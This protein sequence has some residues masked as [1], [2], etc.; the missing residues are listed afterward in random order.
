MYRHQVIIVL[1]FALVNAMLGCSDYGNSNVNNP[2]DTDESNSYESILPDHTAPI[3]SIPWGEHQSI[4]VYGTYA[5]HDST[6]IDY[7]YPSGESVLTDRR[8]LNIHPG[9]T[10]LTL[11]DNDGNQICGASLI[12]LN[13]TLL[14]CSI[15]AEDNTIY[16]EN[17]INSDGIHLTL[18]AGGETNNISFPD[19]L[20]IQYAFEIYET[21]QMD[22]N[23]LQINSNKQ[24]VLANIHDW[25]LP[26]NSLPEIDLSELAAVENILQ[27]E[28][29]IRS[30]IPEL[31]INLPWWLKRACAAYAGT[32]LRNFRGIELTCKVLGTLHWVFKAVC[33]IGA[34]ALIACIAIVLVD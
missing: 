10:G 2:A 34:A 7:T 8:L 32:V 26:L 12:E 30:S 5:N 14:A 21:A 9:L 20:A 28:M 24:I 16:F 4:Q 31:T 18:S 23:N 22:D 13:D 1:I 33:I 15:R 17:I 11:S 19:T 27:D 25:L 3:H 29:F 6:F